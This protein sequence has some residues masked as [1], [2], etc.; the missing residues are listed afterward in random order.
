MA[1]LYYFFGADEEADDLDLCMTSTRKELLRLQQEPELFAS[2]AVE[3]DFWCEVEKCC[4]LMVERSIPAIEARDEAMKLFRESVA[5]HWQDFVLPAR[6]EQRKPWE[7]FL[8]NGA[9][10]SGADVSQHGEDGSIQILPMAA[11]RIMIAMLV[12]YNT[13]VQ[14]LD[15]VSFSILFWVLK[16]DI[17]G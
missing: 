1:K 5:E 11:S 8:H 2:K 15:A 7:Q 4:K 3:E 6:D 12:E 17:E 10:G 16:R 9:P 13:I 14:A